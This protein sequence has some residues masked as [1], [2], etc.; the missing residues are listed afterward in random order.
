MGTFHDDKG[1]LHGITVVVETNGRRIYI[2]RCDEEKPEGAQRLA[3]VDRG[4]RDGGEEK[5]EDS[6]VLALQCPAAADQ[7]HS[8]E[9][10]R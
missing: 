3:K 9:E 8:T 2:G 6:V 4:A 7:E 10:D 1:E 5:A